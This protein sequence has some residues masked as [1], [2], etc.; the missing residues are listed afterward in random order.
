MTGQLL[1]MMLADPEFMAEWRRLTGATLLDPARSGLDIAIDQATGR[2]VRELSA[3]A[4][5]AEDF[6]QRIPR[7]AP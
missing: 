6:A 5:F 7:E 1:Q 3:L 2:E 4:A